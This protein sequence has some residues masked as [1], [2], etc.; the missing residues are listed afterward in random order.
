MKYVNYVLI[1][2]RTIISKIL[3]VS[4]GKI[5]HNRQVQAT[6]RDTDDQKLLPLALKGNNLREIFRQSKTC[7]IIMLTLLVLT[8]EHTFL[9]MQREFY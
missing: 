9:V 1:V 5:L 8:R 2:L 6:T 3:I 7:N 4:S